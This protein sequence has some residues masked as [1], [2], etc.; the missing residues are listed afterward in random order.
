MGEELKSKIDKD[1]ILDKINKDIFEKAGEVLK[2]KAEGVSKVTQESVHI[3]DGVK[4]TVRKVIVDGM[5]ISTE[6]IQ[7]KDGVKIKHSEVIKESIEVEDIDESDEGDDL[8]EGD[9]ED[10]YDI[11]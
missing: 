8:F 2:D 10:S 5:V 7:E 4:T 1:G 11:E 6:S 9:D 3:I